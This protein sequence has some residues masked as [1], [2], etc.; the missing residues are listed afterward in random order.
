MKVLKKGALLLIITCIT[1]SLFTSSCFAT[2]LADW[3]TNPE[4]GSVEQALLD[5]SS[6]LAWAG[7][8]L[9]IIKISQ[10]GMKFMMGT[11]GNK[12]D[13]KMSLLPWFIGSLICVTWLTIGKFII[14]V[15]F[16]G[17]TSGGDPFNI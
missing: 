1:V 8:V 6:V 11:A 17:G 7:F 14:L 9:S 13:A 15:I 4:E 2:E 10:I 16:N 12:G 5:V 3:G